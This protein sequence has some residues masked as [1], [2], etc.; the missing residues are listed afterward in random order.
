MDS[1]KKKTATSDPGDSEGLF[2]RQGVV[3]ILDQ[4]FPWSLEHPCWGAQH[5]VNPDLFFLADL[6]ASSR[7]GA[8]LDLMI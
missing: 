6:A 7:A 4:L 8:G 3:W 2:T 1:I 5:S